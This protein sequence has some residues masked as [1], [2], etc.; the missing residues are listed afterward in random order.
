MWLFNFL[1]RQ[2]AELNPLDN[3]SRSERERLFESAVA[4]QLLA[5]PAIEFGILLLVVTLAVAAIVSSIRSVSVGDISQITPTQ[6]DV[7]EP[8][9]NELALKVKGLMEEPGGLEHKAIGA[10]EWLAQFD[11]GDRIRLGALALV[12]ATLLLISMMSLLATVS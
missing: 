3:L 5:V 6:S 9:K 8:G 2:W 4:W 11:T 12:I 1:R 7:G 10:R